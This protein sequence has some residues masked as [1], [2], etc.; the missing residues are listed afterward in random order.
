MDA[1]RVRLGRPHPPDK[2]SP[3]GGPMAALAPSC[4]LDAMD[5][6]VASSRAGAA[7]NRT[8]FGVEREASLREYKNARGPESR[9]GPVENAQTGPH[10]PTQIGETWQAMP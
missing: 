3:A 9:S 1:R 2:S 5:K 6:A 7:V 8:G 4:G 10:P